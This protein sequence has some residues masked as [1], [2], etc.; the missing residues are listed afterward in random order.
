MKTVITDNGIKSIIEASN[1]GPKITITS[2]K[3]GNTIINPTAT[4]TD[5]TNQVWS[6]GSSY[7]QYLVVDNN[8]FMFRLTLDEG[9]GDFEVGNIGLFLEN[10]DMFTITTLLGTETKSANSVSQ[11]G[12][13]KIY[14]IIIQL[15][16]ISEKIDVSILDSTATNLPTVQ[17]EDD[18]PLSYVTGYNCYQV[19][20]HT[21]MKSSCLA[22]KQDGTWVYFK[23][24]PDESLYNFELA[25]FDDGISVG[26]A[27]FYNVSSNTFAKAT[28]ATGL[29]GLYSSSQTI[30]DKG[31]FK[32]NGWELTAG[33][34]YYLDSDGN[35]TTTQTSAL[36]GLA[37]DTDV[38]YLNYKPETTLNKTITIDV[39]N[40]SNAK[41]PSENAVVDYVSS[42]VALWDNSKADTD[43]ANTDMISDCCI[44]A[45]GGVAN[46]SGLQ[47]RL[48][49]GYRVLF[50]NGRQTNY[51]LKS[52]DYTTAVQL[53]V[54]LP[55]ST[56]QYAV[57]LRSNG[58][59]FYSLKS[60]IKYSETPLTS[61]GYRKSSN[62]NI[63][64]YH[65]GT[66]E[67][68]VNI[69]LVWEGTVT[70]GTVTTSIPTFP[71]SINSAFNQT[72]KKLYWS[73]ATNFT[74][75][76][77]LPSDGQIVINIGGTSYGHINLYVNGINLHN[78]NSY[79]HESSVFMVSAGD[80]VTANISNKPITSKYFIPY[81]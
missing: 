69:V 65:N 43:L 41:Y 13:R 20:Y 54:S 23:I 19:L 45:S 80:I 63:W 3:V 62:R 29:A 8:T 40:P 17:N 76:Q 44:L 15:S 73:N 7:L 33:S 58:T 28:S 70:S 61:T 53:T 42:K 67:S 2:V 38:L 56:N 27:V 16:Q 18:L 31:I 26:D 50:A 72:N 22:I 12:N 35:L 6:G 79:Y 71:I 57:F 60:L 10:G 21:E 74:L 34:L 32:K 77:P 14:D 64:Y 55:T 81:I 59:L 66:S 78:S 75:G 48:P 49:S 47:V 11:N 39:L 30:I 37:V 36:V 46:L 1:E 68:I 9:I 24:N 25:K 52:I 5:V 51:K 4:M